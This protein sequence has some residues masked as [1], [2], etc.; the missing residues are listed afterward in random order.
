MEKGI[1]YIDRCQYIFAALAAAM[2]RP[3]IVITAVDGQKQITEHSEDKSKPPFVFTLYE[4]EGK[5]ITRPAMISKQNSY[6]LANF[7]GMFEIIAY[8]SKR[9]SPSLSSLHIIDLELM[10]IIYALSSFQKLIGRYSQVILLS[11]ARCLY[12]LFSEL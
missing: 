10:G 4:R 6:D 1:L 12:Y 11:D 8:V 5:L 9:I 7:K 2:Y 3:V